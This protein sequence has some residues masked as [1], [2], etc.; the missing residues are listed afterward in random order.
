MPHPGMHDM[1]TDSGMHAG[2]GNLMC[3]VY[4]YVYIYIYIQYILAQTPAESNNPPA[5][6]GNTVDVSSSPVVQ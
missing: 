5:G 3:V 6:S 4:M 1:L 2:F